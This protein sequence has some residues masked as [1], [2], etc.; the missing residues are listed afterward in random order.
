MVDRLSSDSV[1]EQAFVYHTRVR[2]RAVM[3]LGTGTMYVLRHM[4]AWC[5]EEHASPYT[6]T[7]VCNMYGSLL[8]VAVFA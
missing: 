6:C 4:T 2:Y 1:T 5:M 7:Y 8:L 3:V